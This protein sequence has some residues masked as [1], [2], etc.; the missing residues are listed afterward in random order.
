MLCFS[1][2]DRNSFQEIP[3]LADELLRVKDEDTFPMVRP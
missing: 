2:T 1:I 3:T